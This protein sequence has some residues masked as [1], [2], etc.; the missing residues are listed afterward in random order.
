MGAPGDNHQPLIIHMKHDGRITIERI[1]FLRTVYFVV[2]IR[3][4]L[5]AGCHS[6]YLPQE[7]TGALKIRLKL[8]QFFH[9]LLLLLAFGS[10]GRFQAAFLLQL[11]HRDYLR[12][13]LI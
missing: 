4:A 1:Q 12:S 10:S 6:G 8:Y 11:F 13:V 9:R 7:Y 5:P 2:P 3:C